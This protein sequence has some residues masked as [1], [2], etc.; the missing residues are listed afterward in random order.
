MSSS[1]I[2]NFVI[3]GQ[4][5]NDGPIGATGPTG[6]TGATGATGNTGPYG[7]YFVSAQG[8]SNSIVLTFSDGSTAQINGS[9]R[10]ATTADKT[11]G[12]VLGGN[13]GNSIG[14]L[15]NVS[16]GTFNFYGISAYGSLVASLTGDNLE[17]ISIDS[18]YYGSDI[19]GNYDPTSLSAPRKLLYVGNTTTAFGADLKYR[20]DIGTVGLCGAFEFAYTAVSS[21]AADDT[22][23][24]LNSGS[25]IYSY[26]PLKKGFEFEGSTFGVLLN[27]NNGGVFHLRTPIGIRG[28]T[29][30][31]RTNEIA[32]ITLIIDSDNV[33]NF[34]VNVYFAPDE[35]YL[36]CGK[37]ILGLM[38]HDGG[39]TWLAT[40]SHRGHGVEN[41]GRQCVP[42]SLY[43]SCCY[44]KADGTKNCKDYV[45]V[46]ECDKLFGNF[47]PAQS[48][49]DSCGSP[50]SLC[51]ANGTCI[52]NISAAECEK[53]GGDYWQG[54]TC[55]FASGTLN[56]PDPTI[57]TT[58][59]SI[60]ANGRFCYDP[61]GDVKTVCCKDGR[62]LGNYTRVQCE[63]VLGGKSLI[64]AECADV[65]CCTYDSIPGACCI[66]TTDQD[67]NTTST[68]T[69]NL[70]YSE[71]KALNGYYMGPGRQCNDVSCGCVCGNTTTT[72][73]ACC[74][75]G[76]CRNTTFE[77]CA[78]T[79][80]ATQTCNT[81]E[82]NPGI[83]CI[84]GRCS[85]MSELNCIEAGGV[86]T[87]NTNCASTVCT[88]TDPPDPDP[89]S[90][91][92]GTG[93][94]CR[95]GQ[96]SQTTQQNCGG[97]WSAGPCN[98][99]NCSDQDTDNG[100]EGHPPD[101][102]G[103]GGGFDND[104]DGPGGGGSGN[105]NPP[106]T[107]GSCDGLTQNCCCISFDYCY[108]NGSS[109]TKRTVTRKI[110]TPL[111]NP[112]VPCDNFAFDN[113]ADTHLR[114]VNIAKCCAARKGYCTVTGIDTDCGLIPSSVLD[115]YCPQITDQDLYNFLRDEACY[116][117]DYADLT[118]GIFNEI[119]CGT[120]PVICQLDPTN[121]CTNVTTASSVA[122]NAQ[123][124]G[125][126]QLPPL[127]GK[128][129]GEGFDIS[130]RSCIDINGVS[131]CSHGQYAACDPQCSRMTDPCC[132]LECNRLGLKS[133]PEC[134]VESGCGGGTSPLKYTTVPVIKNVKIIINNE[135]HCLPLLCEGN[136]C[137]GYTFCDE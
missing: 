45:T 117:E 18:I 72:I 23:I 33:W 97:S 116:S 129:Q 67:G 133:C 8:V 16:G 89:P 115:E 20:S 78:G 4:S 126:S 64:G 11:A 50:N 130:Y 83:C 109:F 34:P 120:Y 123:S 24:H 42:G 111:G 49:N 66:C 46:E 119:V 56:Y 12:I 53:F 103:Q 95:N 104:D 87:P 112:P 48:C 39:A 108:R 101:R 70:T 107:P 127:P 58:P 59:E 128:Y 134:L 102:D 118:P 75:N 57:Y 80:I 98:S 54:Y 51:C 22:S 44:S 47:Y 94:C 10:G 73:G 84:N 113:C 60:R 86:F 43:G 19:I 36:S 30:S 1:S 90:P 135:E 17:Y 110:C 82:C 32:S 91:P 2:I 29:G 25:K 31:F 7:L 13:T 9:F 21:G 76:I 63:L 96:C 14:V 105:S 81:Y 131:T 68:C 121:P 38:S 132:R 77:N 26:G 114:F 93:S 99:A 35:N 40:A 92:V 61:C 15:Y 124:C 3:Y 65:D 55:G 74:E 88:D 136:D 37:N 69:P 100:G 85:D 79:F 125:E 106:S 52:E 71:C 137:D 27:A 122:Y 28:I 41:V 62:C 5:G 6:P